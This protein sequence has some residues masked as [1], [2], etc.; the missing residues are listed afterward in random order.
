M[1]STE[2]VYTPVQ[3]SGCLWAATKVLLAFLVVTIFG[4]GFLAGF[5]MMAVAGMLM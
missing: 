1:V 4:I 5:F 2:E 3:T